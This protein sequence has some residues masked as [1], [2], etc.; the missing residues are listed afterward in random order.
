MGNHTIL[1]TLYDNSKIYVNT[2]DASITPHILFDGFWEKWITDVFVSLLK[3]GMTV[4]D[5]GA[6]CGYYSLLAARI[7]GKYGKVHAFEPNPVH[8]ENLIKSFMINGYNHASL[9]KVALSNKAE[10]KTFH[11]LKSLTGSSS[12]F[13]FGENIDEI[14]KVNSIVTQTVI[15]N[16]YLQNVIPD[17]IKIDIEGAEPLIMDS[18]I[19]VLNNNRNPVHIIMEYT[20][21]LWINHGFKPNEVLQKLYD[22]GFSIE[23]IQHDS[24]LNS[25][26]LDE[27]LSMTE[28]IKNEFGH[29]DLK[30]SRR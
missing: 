8:H 30:I 10:N 27:L 16:E 22:N 18:L 15:L 17:V 28:T 26:S 9:H 7:V 19:E 21:S 23:V 24:N 29:I 13:A 6:N 25:V 14:D 3:P 1:T 5:I 2:M 4:L 20:P 12:L 11:T